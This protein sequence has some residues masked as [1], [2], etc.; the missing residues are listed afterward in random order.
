MCRI[1]STNDIIGLKI[2]MFKYINCW[3]TYDHV[4]L[5]NEDFHVFVDNDYMWCDA[6]TV[7]DMDILIL[8]DMGRK[9]NR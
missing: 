4:F 5:I 1:K 7:M 6:M 3:L 8:R 2:L 9:T